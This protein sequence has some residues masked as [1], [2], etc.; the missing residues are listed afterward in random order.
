MKIELDTDK[1]VIIVEGGRIPLHLL[2]HIA[3][4]SP[5]VLYRI[6]RGVDNTITVNPVVAEIVRT[7]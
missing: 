4:P 1:Q 2:L 6:Y 5:N 3:N 7:R